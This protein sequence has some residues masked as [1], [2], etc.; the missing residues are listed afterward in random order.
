MRVLLFGGSGQLGTDI[1]RL[2]RDDEIVAPSSSEVNVEDHE[3]LRDT[4]S[5]AAPELVVN[6][7]AYNKVDAAESEPERAFAINAF[8][9]EAMAQAANEAGARFLTFSTDYVFDGE[10]GEPYGESDRPDPQTVYGVSKLTGELLAERQHSNALVV[11]V[12]GLYCTRTSTSKGYTFIDRIIARARAG[13]RIEVVSDQIVSPTYA[14]HVA[15]TVR[16]V[17]ETDVSGV[18]HMVNEGAI[19]WYDFAVEAIRAA[20]VEAAI[21]P[22]SYTTWPSTAKRPRYSALRNSRLAAAGFSMPGWQLGIADYLRDK[23]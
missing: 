15:V 23:S 3:A 4:V 9:V 20:G 2:W 22:V 5:R 17:L 11:R 16:A 14:G 7:T 19:S 10:K 6:C 13:E 8:A 12:C 21:E 1:Q 18:V